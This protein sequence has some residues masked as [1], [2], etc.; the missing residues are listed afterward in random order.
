MRG[1]SAVFPPGFLERNIGSGHLFLLG[2]LLMPAFLFHQSLTLRLL[3]AALFAALCLLAGRRIRI[4]PTVLTVAGIVACNLLVP[5]GRVL[6]SIGRFAVTDEALL[7]GLR[8]AALFEGLILLSR[9]YVR[10]DL[11]IPGSFG[12]L[13][14]RSLFY[15]ER[16][17]SRDRGWN[18]KRILADLDAMLLEIQAEGQEAERAPALGRTSLRG[19]LFGCALLGANWAAFFLVLAA[20]K[21]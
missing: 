6:F 11:R 7:S 8:K 21:G 5:T 19:I 10:P 14:S 2:I 13:L 9:F 12:G 17:M 16:I 20:G 15:F 1:R 3:Q 4:L 18:R